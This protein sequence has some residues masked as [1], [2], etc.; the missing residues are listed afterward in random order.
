M[1][2]YF[3]PVADLHTH[4]LRSAHAYSTL[5]EN[6]AAGA[7]LGLLAVACTDHGPRITDGAHPWHFGNMGRVPDRIQGLRH[8]RGIEANVCDCRG[9]LD[10]SDDRL[11]AMEIVI[12]SMHD[13]AMPRGTRRRITAAWLAIA[14]NPLVD[15]IGHCGN[16]AFP[17][18]IDT[19]V[20][21]FGK[22]GK[23]VE[24]NEGTFVARRHSVDNCRA[25]IAACKRYGVR[26]VVN[27]DAHYLTEVG[28][29]E[30]CVALL[31]EQA[32]PLELVI[33][34][35]RERLEEFLGEKQL[36]L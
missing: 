12:A 17:F 3:E 35:S 4:T 1:G 5:T 14:A 11:D 23:V 32:F 27:S 25:V 6:A 31:Q 33:N 29:M 8:L 15:I 13:G 28:H 16:S 24:V 7:A 9:T 19:V 36:T 30:R 26:V 2:Q 22:H 10:L 20:A 21:A 34:S 18:D